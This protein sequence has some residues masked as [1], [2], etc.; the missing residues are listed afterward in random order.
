VPIQFGGKKAT[1]TFFPK[2]LECLAHFQPSGT[3]NRES[4]I[5]RQVGLPDVAQ[6][7]QDNEGK[8]NW[9]KGFFFLLLPYDD[10]PLPEREAHF[11]D[12]FNFFVEAGGISRKRRQTA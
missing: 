1:G 10:Q 6:P 11:A 9:D 8:R 7:S 5:F 3:R 2:H 12:N 4:M